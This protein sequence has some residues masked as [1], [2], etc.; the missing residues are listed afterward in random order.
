MTAEP[1]GTLRR[2]HTCGDLRAR[3]TGATCVLLG[4]VHT[5]RDH[6]GVLFIDLRDRYGRTQVVVEPSDVSPEVVQTAR[7]LASEYVVAVT[8]H[9]VCRPEGMVNTAIATGAIE[10]RA[11]DVRLL[12]T[13]RALPFVLADEEAAAA[14]SE[15]LRLRYRY[16]DLR[17]RELQ[18]TLALRHRVVRRV[19]EALSSDGF[20]EIDTPLLVRPTPEGARDFIVPARLHPGMFY[21]LPQS[22]QLY[23][24]ILMV[25]GF[26]RYFQIAHC[27]RDEDLRAD[28]QPEHTQIDLEMTFVGEEDV[29]GVVERMFESVMQ[30]V[31]GAKFDTP[32]PR[33][34]YAEAMSRFGS[35]KPD[36]R[37]ELELTDVS[38]PARAS[39]SAIFRR[40]VEEGGAVCALAVPGAHPLSR[41]D[42]DALEALAKAH[43]LGGLAWTRVA[44]SGGAE[45]GVGKLLTLG[46]AEAI[47]AATG[48][49]GGG[50]VLF[51]AGPRATVQKALGAVRLDAG[52]RL[53]RPDPLDFRFVWIR[54]FPLFEWDEESQRWAPAHHMFCMP[55]DEDVA[56]LETDPGRVYARQYDLALN[57]TELGSGSI[58]IHSSELQRRVMQVVGLSEEQAREK[59]GFLL[60]ALDYGAPPH[61]GI[62]LGVDRII[63]LLAGRDSIRDT[64]AFPKTARAASLMDGAPGVVDPRDLEVL[65]IRVAERAAATAEARAKA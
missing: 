29:W 26:D 56:H 41:K 19:R 8:G 63:M 40:A 28:R 58:R 27:L 5:V 20:L 3:D 24:Q 39:Q 16:L 1:L 11:T 54:D 2:T 9:V 57:G 7:L 30:E 42:I 64:I 45:G 59:F 49:D 15:D 25:S 10:V 13:C 44:T 37:F 65:G 33:L 48:A 53:F 43:G 36:M 4:W 18:S 31:P 6:G 46:T 12:A 55:R 51:G 21:A 62:A 60:E 47:F 50:T 22:P 34:P 23:K 17:R 38:E 32:F 35:D 52:R 14:V 61:G